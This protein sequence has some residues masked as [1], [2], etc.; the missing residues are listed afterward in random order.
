MKAVLAAPGRK[1]LNCVKKLQDIDPYYPNAIKSTLLD[2]E[3][4][5]TDKMELLR[6]QVEAAFTLRSIRV[7]NI[8]YLL[9]CF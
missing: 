8:L 9:R 4:P 5:N 3:I 2:K 7:K 1:L 6:I